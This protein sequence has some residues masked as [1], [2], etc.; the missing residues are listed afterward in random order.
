MIGLRVLGQ[1]LG[2]DLSLEFLVLPVRVGQDLLSYDLEKADQEA[3][4]P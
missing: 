3:A 2:L 4:R 1:L